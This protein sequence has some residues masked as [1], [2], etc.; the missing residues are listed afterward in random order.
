MKLQKTVISQG[1][2]ILEKSGVVT[3]NAFRFSMI[4]DSPD[5]ILFQHPFI[6]INL[7]NFLSEARKVIEEASDERAL[8]KVL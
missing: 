1:I 3:H 2:S 6:L 4:K 7:A 8:M 5:I